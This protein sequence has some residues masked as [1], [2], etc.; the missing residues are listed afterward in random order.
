MRYRLAIALV[1]LLAVAGRPAVVPA[2]PAAGQVLAVFGS[3]FVESAGRKAPL[4]LGSPVQVGDSV[5]VPSGAKLKLRMADGSVISVASGSRLTIA[6]FKTG[7]DGQGREAK[8]ALA[9]GLLRAVVA[10]VSGPSHFEVST[11]TGVAAVRSTDLFVEASANL[12]QVGVL[13][14]EVDCTSAATGK[15][16]LLKPGWGT[17]M[18]Q[19]LDPVPPRKWLQSEFDAVIART[20][21]GTP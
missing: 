8:V 10:S 16:V 19:G 20:N 5:E 17:H 6:D 14:G 9:N 13:T 11:A 4:Q 18:Y 21:L 1:A 7:A 12:T 15:S 3:A 2:A